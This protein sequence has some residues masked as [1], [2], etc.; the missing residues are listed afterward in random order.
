MVDQSAVGT[1]F[2]PVQ[3]RVEGSRVR[4]FLDTIGEKSPVYRD[5]AAARAAGYAD[6]PIPPTFL[7]CLEM[8]GARD[9][10]EAFSLL[11]IDIARVLHG[12]QRFVY[13]APAVVGDVLTFESSVSGVAVKKGGA[14]TIVDVTTKITNQDGRHVADTTRA[15]VVRN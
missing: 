9:P 11:G 7:F 14:L 12:E 1:R 5:A 10:F 6:I 8:M 3:A 13:H 15:I 4:D 2:T